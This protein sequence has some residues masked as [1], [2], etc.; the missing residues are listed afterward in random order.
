MSTTPPPVAPIG[1]RSDAGRVRLPAH[2]ASTAASSS[3]SAGVARTERNDTVAGTERKPYDSALASDPDVI[4]YRISGAFFFGAAATVAAALDRIAE[5]P[6]AY[7]IDFSAV[8]IIDSTAAATI[9]GFVRKAS[10]HGARVFISGALPPV[11][12]ALLTHGLRPPR[13]RYRTRLSEALAA[14]R[15]NPEDVATK[16]TS[17]GPVEPLSAALESNR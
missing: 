14:A 13:V 11:R 15:G 16:G 4:V 1:A 5:H 3:R 9:E 6:K 12:R 7:V 8:P 10:R 17:S 2:R